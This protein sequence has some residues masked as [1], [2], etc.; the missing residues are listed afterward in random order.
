[1]TTATHTEE[2]Q[3]RELLENRVT[4]MKNRDAEALVAGYAPDAVIFD[5]APPLRQPSSVLDP[6]S[7]RAWLNTFEGPIHY[8]IRDLEITAMQD[9]AFAHSLHYLGATPSGASEGF[10]LWFRVTTCLRKVDGSWLITHEHESTPFE[11]DGS[12]NAAI[13]LQP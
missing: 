13:D 9:L 11:M 10:G 12:F 5:L 7:K 6:A 8:E 2:A 1:M 4:A 3:I